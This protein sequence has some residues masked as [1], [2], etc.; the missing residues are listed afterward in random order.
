MNKLF[1]L[2]SQCYAI[3]FT[4][5]ILKDLVEGNFNKVNDNDF[6]LLP[7]THALLAGGKAYSSYFVL[8]SAE[9][10]RLSCGGHGFAHYS[11]MPAIYLESAPNVQQMLIFKVTLE[12]EN[13]IMFL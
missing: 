7:V 4:G 13:Q 12:G 10:S 9:W 11:G 5:V 2:L 3:L 6:S 8:K 1:P